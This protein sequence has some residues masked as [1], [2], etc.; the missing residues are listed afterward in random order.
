MGELWLGGGRQYDD[1]WFL[2]DVRITQTLVTG[3]PTT[4]LDAADRSALPGCT[5]GCAGLVADLSA[6]PPIAGAPGA[7][8]RLSGGA[9]TAAACPGT[10]L[11]Y[12]FGVDGDGD[13]QLGGALDWFITA[14]AIASETT[15]FPP[16]AAT[17]GVRVRCASDPACFADR[18]AL[19][20]VACPPPET[21]APD[22]WWSS[23]RMEN[24]SHQHDLPSN[25]A[26]K[27]EFRFVL[28]D[29]GQ[30]G[31]VASGRLSTLRS[32]G[33]FQDVDCEGGRLRDMTTADAPPPNDG[34]WYLLR[35]YN[36]T[37]CNETQS[38]ST[39]HPKENPDDPGKRDREVPYCY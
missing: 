25:E 37:I 31:S 27:P 21:F 35:G 16:A 30:F 24:W 28:N 13:G 3:S 4:A 17:Y 33:S 32:T 2:D 20:T 11:L 29:L 8:V 14:P 7:P 18:T 38:F 1:G 36:P 19:L 23:V 15:V 22:A 39:Y 10:T 5:G 34:Y 26:V 12:E 6:E 9:S